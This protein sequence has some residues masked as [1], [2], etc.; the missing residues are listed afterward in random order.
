MTNESKKLSAFNPA[1][2]AIVLV[3]HQPGV[4]A[5][6][7]SLPA[8]TV[9]SNTALLARLGEELKIPM[10]ITSTRENLE[11]LGTNLP[12]IQKAA[13]IAYGKRIKRAGTL[14]AFHDKVFIDAVKNLNRPN[15]VMAGLL[16]DVCLFH[17]VASALETGYNVQVVAD[18]SGTSNTL[19]DLVTYDRLRD[20]GAIITSSYGILFELYPDLGSTE[21]M[22][23]EGIVV[24]S[25]ANHT[26][27]QSFPMVH[28]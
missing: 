13:P 12:E 4:L 2:I 23:A 6:V 28:L 15:L 18:A 24:S 16:T 10:V 27:S 14:N 25:V 26:M 8:K 9:T 21:G 20:L 3:D 7:Q 19:A 1:N 17:S 11:F 5:M 22:K